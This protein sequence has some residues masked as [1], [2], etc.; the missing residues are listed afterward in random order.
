MAQFRNA[1]RDL[2]MNPG[3]FAGSPGYGFALQQG[4]DATARK[5]DRGSGNRLAE[6]TKYATGLA[7]QDYGNEFQ[8]RLQAAGLEQEGELATGAQG[9]DRERLALEGE[10]GRGR[11]GVDQGQLALQGELGRGELG[12]ARGRLGLDTLRSDRDYDIAGRGLDDA[13]EGRW[14]DHTLGQERNNIAAAGQ[15]N[16]FTLGA[17]GVETNR[18]NALTN[19]GQARSNDWWRQ[20]EAARGW[21]GSGPARSRFEDRRPSWARSY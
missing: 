5:T 2:Q 12:V 14:W 17:A 21:Q 18:Y 4:L 1:L 3:S 20:D 11:L 15:A 8:R 16:D 9:I 19:R 10:L 13:R 6:L 7:S